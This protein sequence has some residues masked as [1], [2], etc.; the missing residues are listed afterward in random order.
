[1]SGFGINVTELMKR[2]GWPSDLNRGK[3]AVEGESMSWLG[4]LVLIAPS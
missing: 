1:M 2:C 4:G 3:A